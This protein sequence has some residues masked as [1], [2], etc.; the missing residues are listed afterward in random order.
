MERDGECKKQGARVSA[1][2][3]QLVQDLHEKLAKFLCTN[4]SIILFPKFQTSTMTHR[5]KR[6]FKARTARALA[7]WSHYCF[8]QLLLQKSR[9]YPCCRV[10]RVNE[11]YT[12]KTC[13][14]CGQVNSKLRGRMTLS[15]PY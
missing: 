8:R 5:R 2:I 1:K 15:C 12:S 7:T 13:G 10:I 3:H 6:K 14:M 4:F 9:E 11:A